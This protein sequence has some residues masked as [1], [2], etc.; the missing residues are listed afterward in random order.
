MI[1][2]QTKDN[3]RD[4]RPSME[5]WTSITRWCN[6]EKRLRSRSMNRTH[7]EEMDGSLLALRITGMKKEKSKERKTI[8]E[9][10][11]GG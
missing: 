1:L 5:T 3:T 10:E 4:V 9:V 8:K 7:K 11:E 6:N 2:A